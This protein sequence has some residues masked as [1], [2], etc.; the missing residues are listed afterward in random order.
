M[1][2]DLT[3][4]SFGAGLQ[5][6]A[7]LVMSA[8]R[9]RDTPKIDLAVFADTQ[10]EPQWV[11]DHLKFM[12]GWA[13]DHGI[14][15]ETV[16]AGNL[17]QDVIDRRAPE[18]RRRRF[19][20]VPCWTEGTNKRTGEAEAVPLRRQCTQDYKIV[21]EHPLV[22]MGITRLGCASLLDEVGIPLPK[23]SACVYCPYHDDAYWSDLKGNFP[24]EWDRAIAFDESFRNMTQSG[25][26]QPVYLHRSLMPL[27]MVDLKPETK[28][29]TRGLFDNGFLNECEGMC[30]V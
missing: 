12:R 1:E 19:V 26:K 2:Y 23:K 15:I 5:S 18:Q 16:S 17:A 13:F 6:T 4:L 22:D 29:G 27:A 24:D 20:A 7:L 3:Y 30:G 10:G 11:Y 25:V 28:E 14:H 21:K 9:L 8:I